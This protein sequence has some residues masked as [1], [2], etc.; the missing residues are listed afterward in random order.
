[1]EEAKRRR[2]GDKRKGIFFQIKGVGKVGE[3]E[4]VDG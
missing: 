1:M 2:R 4:E 3:R